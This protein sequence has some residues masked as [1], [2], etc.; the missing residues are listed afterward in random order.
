[1]I[2]SR[3]NS[4]RLPGKALIEINGK[5]MIQHV[6]ER[7]QE[8]LP[9]AEIWVATDDERIK[10]AIEHKANVQ[11]TSPNH[12]TGTDR[13]A[14]VACSRKWDSKDLIINIQG[15]EPFIPPQLIQ[16]LSH[17]MCLGGYSMGTMASTFLDTAE[18]D[19]PN[20]I[21]VTLKKNG[22]ALY[23]SRSK[24]P[25]QRDSSPLEGA[26]LSNYYKH[27]GIYAYTVETLKTITQAPICTIEVMEKL[28]QLRALYLGI[29]IQVFIWS[30]HSPQG[31]DTLDD[32]EIIRKAI[33][34]Q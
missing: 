4:K 30:G 29:P 32:L 23:F 22:E 3:Y 26:S 7:A 34:L 24:I 2:P 17:E 25:F 18:L 31:I 33:P 10:K 11:M 9:N 27:I 8:A 1:M 14:E 13:I 28:E 19:N 16:K 12:T 15:D 5:P 20:R 21:K 6:V